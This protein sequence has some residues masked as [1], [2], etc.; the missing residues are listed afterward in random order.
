MPGPIS[1]LAFAEKYLEQNFI[2]DEK[3]LNRFIQ[4]TIFP[5]IRYFT[6]LDRRITHGRFAPNKDFLNV[7]SFEAGWK[8]HLYF[9]HQWAKITRESEFFNKYKED[10]IISALAAKLIEDRIDY[11]KIKNLK[12]YLIALR[13]IELQGPILDIPVKKIQS[14]YSHNVDYIISRDFK[15]FKSFLKGIFNDDV[16]DKIEKRIKEMKSDKR[17]I[18]FLSK[19]VEKAL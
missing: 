19:M 16:L 1:H 18:A 17:L 14:Y 5:D 6:H 13:K 11:K 9:D 3:E 10:M 2:N 12:K 7:S 8:L 4:G 15:A